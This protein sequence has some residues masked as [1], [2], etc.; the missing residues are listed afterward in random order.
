[1][2]A[3]GALRLFEAAVEREEDLLSPRGDRELVRRDEQTF[4]MNR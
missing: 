4:S 1:V 3:P 2:G